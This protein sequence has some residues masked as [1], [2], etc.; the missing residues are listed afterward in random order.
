MAAIMLSFGAPVPIPV[1][2]TVWV[3]GVKIAMVLLE[4]AM[5]PAMRS[6]A[7]VPRSVP[8]RRAGFKRL[9]LPRRFP[10]CAKDAPL[11]IDP[12]LL[13][14]RLPHLLDLLDLLDLAF[15]PLEARFPSNI[16]DP[17]DL[18][19]RRMLYAYCALLRLRPIVRRGRSLGA[20][21]PMFDAL[22]AM[23]GAAITFLV[24]IL[25]HGGDRD[26][27][28]GHQNGNPKFTHHLL[29]Q[30]KSDLVSRWMEIGSEQMSRC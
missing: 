1:F 27:R 30:I 21:G 16:L 29:H 22:G 8:G 15:A 2:T 13:S 28:S 18:R 24:L 3:A 9:L 4:I 20:F 26:H 12:N 25:R 17:L 6:A 7:M 19:A 23:R 10:D 11:L 14:W 5:I